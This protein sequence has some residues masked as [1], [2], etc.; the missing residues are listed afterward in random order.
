MVEITSENFEEE[1][2]KCN[3]EVFVVFSSARCSYCRD[4]KR[5]VRV[6]QRVLTDI[7]FCSVNVDMERS[8]AAKYQV[9]RLPL[10]IVFENGKEKVR[11]EG[12]LTKS[13][14]YKLLGR[15]IRIA[16]K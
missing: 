14:V 8:L 1:I 2:E 9:N 15:T 10:S 16:V 4:L 6:L 5:L 3:T 7:K 12:A 13:E 11:A